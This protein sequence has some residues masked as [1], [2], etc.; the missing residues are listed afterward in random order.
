M[1]GLAEGFVRQVLDLQLEL[2]DD[3]GGP[4]EWRTATSGGMVL[5][6]EVMLAFDGRLSEGARELRLVVA[7]SGDVVMSVTL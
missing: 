5:P 7:A 1:V 4:Y 2:R 6:E 3:R